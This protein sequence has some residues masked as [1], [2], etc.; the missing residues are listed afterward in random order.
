MLRICLLIS[1]VLCAVILIG[2]SGSSENSNTMTSNTN[3]TAS[4]PASTTPSTTAAAG[5]K[6]GVAD[7]DDFI[8]KYEACVNSKVP[9][10]ARTQFQSAVK[11]WRDSWKKLADNPATKGTLAAACKQAA[12]QQEAALKQYGCTW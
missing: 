3:R 8:A 5:Q 7:C 11:Q 2:C 10:A 9:E 1:C 12:T 6:I 4:T